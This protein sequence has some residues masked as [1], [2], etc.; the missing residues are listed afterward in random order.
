MRSR[1]FTRV[2]AMT[3]FSALAISA[4]LAAQEQGAGRQHKKE[5]HRYKLIDLGTFGGP[6]SYFNTLHDVAPFVPALAYFFNNAQTVNQRGI[7]AGW[8]DTSAP[9]PYPA[10]CFNPDCFVSHGFLWRDGLLTDLGPLAPGWS[11]AATWINDNGQAVGLSEN[12][13]I[14]PLTGLPEVRGVLWDNGQIIDLGTLGGNASLALGVNEDGQ[15]AGL[16]LNAIPD[17]FSVYDFLIYGSSQGTQTRAVLWHDGVMQDLGTLGGPDAYAAY[18]NER[19]QVAG[20]SYTNSTP[21]PITHLPTFHPFLWDKEAGMQ[22][23][24]SLGGTVTQQ[25][26]GPNE[27]GQVVGAT[28]LA[29]DSTFHPFLWDGKKLI[30]LGTLGRPKR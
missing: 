27:R 22:D 17:P 20:S 19:G 10:F 7:S 30:D 3:I 1:T 13:L 28:T 29:G 11:S 21:N 15:V 12:G 4:P 24:G 5:H 18:I 16:A 8:T 25:V 23:L 26:V 6:S 14:D 2:I 9:D